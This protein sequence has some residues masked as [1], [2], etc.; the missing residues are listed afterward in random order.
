MTAIKNNL[1]HGVHA[2]LVILKKIPTGAADVPHGGI[3]QLPLQDERHITHHTDEYKAANDVSKPPDFKPLEDTHFSGKY[4]SLFESSLKGGVIQAAPLVAS[5]SYNSE[6]VKPVHENGHP[7]EQSGSPNSGFYG[8][9]DLNHALGGAQSGPQNGPQNGHAQ[10]GPTPEHNSPIAPSHG[11]TS[12][13]YN[14]PIAPSFNG[15]YF[16][17]Q[18]HSNIAQSFNQQ[19]HSNIGPAFNEITLNGH[20][21]SQA[22]NEQLLNSHSNIGQTLNGHSFNGQSLNGNSLNEQSINGHSFNGQ[23]LNEHSLNANIGQSFNEHGHSFNGQS[24]NIGHSFDG[25]AIHGQS[26]HFSGPSANGFS[27]SEITAIAGPTPVGPQQAHL[28]SIAPISTP[29]HALNTQLFKPTQDES[30]V[31][32]T[33]E[34]EQGHAS[35]NNEGVQT[36]LTPPK[37]DQNVSPHISQFPYPPP[38]MQHGFKPLDGPQKYTNVKIPFP[39]E[40]SIPFTGFGHSGSSGYASK[41]KHQFGPSFDLQPTGDLAVP[42]YQG[43]LSFDFVKSVGYELPHA[44]R[45][46]Q[47][48]PRPFQKTGLR[49]NGRTPL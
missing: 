20:F 43:P 29:P 23:S 30:L 18:A 33:L 21:N 48:K 39:H 4:N 40:A 34:F 37:A 27:S 26:A 11:P 44:K 13:E 15:Q 45:H 31:K 10:N 36:Y 47:N 22:L 16:T 8:H 3:A 28:G 6:G 46:T 38:T 1:P 14:G 32:P 24:F 5:F 17:E 2:G 7:I 9:P 25:P 42:P 35:P 12:A 49:V 41:F 19:S